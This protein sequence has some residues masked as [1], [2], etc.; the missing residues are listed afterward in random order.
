[1][2]FELLRLELCLVHGKLCHLEFQ[3]VRFHIKLGFNHPCVKLQS[4]TWL[5]GMDRAGDREKGDSSE[6]Q[7]GRWSGHGK[8]P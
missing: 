6:G 4:I 8:T 5:L 1:M 2:Q 7:E 3:L